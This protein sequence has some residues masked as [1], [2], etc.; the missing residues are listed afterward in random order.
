MLK[1]TTKKNEPQAY[2]KRLFVNMKRKRS[3]LDPSLEYID[4][5]SDTPIIRIARG[6]FAT[7]ASGKVDFS[8]TLGPIFGWRTVA[9]LAV[10]GAGS[11]GKI[12]ANKCIGLFMPGTHKIIPCFDSPVHHP[13]INEAAIFVERACVQ[14]SMT[15][16]RENTDDGVLRYILFAVEMS[17]EKVQVV[18]VVNCTPNSISKKDQDMLDRVVRLMSSR[19]SLFH[20]IWIHC[21]PTSRH[22]NAITGRLVD[23]WKCV[24]GAPS[25]RVQLGITDGPEVL[26]RL[27]F[28]PNVFRQANLAGFSRIIDTIRKYIP[29]KSKVIE[30]YGGVG[31]IGLNCLDL[32]K[33][34]EC[35]D[36]NPYNVECF[37]MC[38]ADFSA[39]SGK[40]KVLRKAKYL[41]SSA[42][43]RAQQ[44]VFRKFHILLVDPP[45]KGL[46]EEVLTELL[47]P[48]VELEKNRLNRIIYVSCGFKAFQRDC[49]RL[50]ESGIWNLVHAEGHILFPGS[51]HIETLAIF[52]RM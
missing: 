35:S 26:P 36:E 52:D 11:D 30:L 4:R 50:L 10:R 17:T 27:S 41:N 22:D 23:S 19:E 42:S 29:K 37:N 16:Y 12:V 31:T 32:V 13:R 6:F 7:L 40:E 21:H 3:F 14:S 25:L 47:R 1:R 9:K 38:V 45:R 15:G 43:E 18:L 20:S 33:K 48:K 49:L 24:F 51:D 46:D 8:V 44:D 5:P 28:P 34:L 2:L 39:E